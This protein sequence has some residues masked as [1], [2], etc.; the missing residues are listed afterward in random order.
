[1]KISKETSCNARLDR[2]NAPCYAGCNGNFRISAQQPKVSAHPH[3]TRSSLKNSAGIFVSVGRK[4]LIRRGG[5][6]VTA[7]PGT[8]K[9]GGWVRKA[10]ARVE[11]KRLLG[12]SLADLAAEL[13]SVLG[14]NAK[15]PTVG[16]YSR[17]LKA[18]VPRGALAFSSLPPIKAF[19][20][21]EQGERYVL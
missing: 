10:R 13:L 5:P 6:T 2:V 8:T 11:A 15:R 18:R 12:L 19:S 16:A 3:N 21:K 9:C 17:G 7:K 14:P 4:R 1:M 20:S